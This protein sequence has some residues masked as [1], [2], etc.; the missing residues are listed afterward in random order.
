MWEACAKCAPSATQLLALP[1]LLPITH[2]AS[3]P[4]VAVLL[5][6]TNDLRAGLRRYGAKLDSWTS[7]ARAAS[8]AAQGV[9][10]R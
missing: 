6:G 4:K 9:A 8:E 1:G 7:K 3:Q 2:A 5:I 10:G